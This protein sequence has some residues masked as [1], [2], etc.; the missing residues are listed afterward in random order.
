MYAL[1]FK[2]SVQ[3]DFR[4]IGQAAARRVLAAIREK[5]VHDPRGAGKPLRGR[6]GTLWSF[7]VGDWRVLY[8]FSETEVWILVVRV[9]PRRDVYDKLER[10]E[11]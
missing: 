1:R 7:R 2:K 8:T 6:H 5:L 3:K 10:S 4:R 11:E 9:G